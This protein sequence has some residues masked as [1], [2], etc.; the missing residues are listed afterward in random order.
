MNFNKYLILVILIFVTKLICLGNYD[1]YHP[2]EIRYASIAMRIALTNN[3]LMPYFTPD[4]PFFGKPPLAFLASAAFFKLFGFSE[5]VGRLPH[6]LALIATCGFLFH[7]LKKIYD[8]ETAIITILV[9]SSCSLFYALH[10]V[11]TEAF[12]LLGMTMIIMGFYMQIQSNKSKNIYGYLL[13]IGAAIAMLSKG[14]V[15]ILMPGLAIFIYLIITK[16]FKE[17]LTKLP[18]IY[19]ILIFLALS[20]PWFILAE[21]KYPGFLEYFI[22]GENL[23]RFTTSGWQGDRYGFAHKVAIGSIW[24]FFVI[25]TL[26]AILIVIFKAKQIYITIKNLILNNRNLNINKDEAFKFFLIITFV[27]L[28]ILTFMRNMIIPYA[29]YSLVGFAVIIA[30]ISVLNKY[31]RF[32]SFIGYFTIIIYLILIVLFSANIK[33]VEQ[34]LNYQSYLIKHIDKSYMAQL[35]S[36]LY[37]LEIEKKLFSGYWYFKDRVETLT[38]KKLL[39]KMDSKT[40][41]F[42]VISNVSQYKKLPK[43]YQLKLIEIACAD[44]KS[45]SCLYKAL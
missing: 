12:L 4:L 37:Y 29:I 35:D 8:K 41:P 34:K 42:F 6:F 27:P 19:G 3:Y 16:R 30:R 44:S 13:F 10:S 23:K 33:A 40:S 39:D 22:V 5:F 7:C 38:Q 43:K 17:A 20:L 45:N 26:P 1:F 24:Y 31:Y 2:S 9:L 36:K 28:I 18:I 11:M 15:G 32:L 21:L 14:P 25:S